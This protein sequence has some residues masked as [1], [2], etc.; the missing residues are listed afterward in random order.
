ME[1]QLTYNFIQLTTMNTQT[2]IDLNAAK[3]AASILELAPGLKHV[4]STGGGEFAGP[5]PFCGGVDRFRAQAGS[6]RWYCRNCGDGRWHDVID[7]IMRR[8]RCSLTEAAARLGVAGVQKGNF[9]F[10]GKTERMPYQAPDQAWQKKASTIVRICQENLFKPVGSKALDYLLGRGLT[11]Q[12]IERFQL[13]YSPS[14]KVGDLDV[15]EGITIPAV[16]GGKTWYIKVRNIAGDKEHRYLAVKGSKTNALFAGDRIKEFP[17]SMIVEGEFNAMILDQEVGDVMPVCS[18]GSATNKLDI[19][20]WGSYL[21]NPAYFLCL[22]DNDPAG[23]QGFLNMV[24]LIGDRAKRV[25]LPGEGDIND[26]HIAG[27]DVWEWLSHEWNKID[28]VPNSIVDAI[29][30]L[31]GVIHEN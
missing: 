18:L 28:P 25:I 29:Q 23:N 9:S 14:M 21:V 15:W 7:F 13:G 31:G 16:N 17:F 5:C 6:N 30:K 4:A 12:T 1:I 20:T 19:L 26:F 10:V 22:F 11:S 27:G 3:Q 2:N 24:D 8:D